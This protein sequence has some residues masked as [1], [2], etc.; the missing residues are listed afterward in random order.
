MSNKDIANS[1]E[2]NED[3]SDQQAAKR[4]KTS[5]RPTRNRKQP[6][7]LGQTEGET[8]DDA[9]FDRANSIYALIATD[10]E[11]FPETSELSFEASSENGEE[12][13]KND[14]IL[15]SMS[16][17]EKIIY[18]M[19]SDVVVDVRLL[20]QKLIQM[21]SNMGSSSKSDSFGIPRTA[22]QLKYSDLTEI[23]LPITTLE[24]LGK[25]N[26]NLTKEDFEKK[27]VSNLQSTS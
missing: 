25:F 15:T 17:G 19:L 11:I 26:F 16:P 8:N 9:L 18:K 20:K 13:K 27:A 2:Q 1:D 6:E 4:R 22:K 23:G 3:N 5:D 24:G 10:N 12:P 7:R 21:E 14:E